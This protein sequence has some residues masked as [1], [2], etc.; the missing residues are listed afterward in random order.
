VDA[1]L[2]AAFLVGEVRREPG[3]FLDLLRRRL[4]QHEFRPSERFELDD[5][6]HRNV[7]DFPLHGGRPSRGAQDCAID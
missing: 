5:L 4:R 6:G 1:H 7:A 2:E 3:K